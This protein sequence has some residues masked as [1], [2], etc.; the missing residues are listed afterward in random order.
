VRTI[1]R[2]V[3][4]LALISAAG[5]AAFAGA[6]PMPDVQHISVSINRPPEEVYD[7]ASDPRNLPRWAAGLARSDVK[8]DGDSWVADSPM[9]KIKIRFAERNAFGV[10]DHDV[11]TEAGVTIHNPMRVVPSGRGS[12]FSFT[13]IRQPGT[14][15]QQFAED[16]AAVEKDLKTLKVLLESSRESR[17]ARVE[18]GRAPVNTIQIYYEI[19]GPTEGT[20]LVLLHGGGSTIDVTFGRILPFLARHRRVIAVEEQGHGRT[21]DRDTPVRFET[22]ADDVAGLLKHLQIDKA[23]LFG[24]SNG[25]NVALQVAIRHPQRVRKLVFGSS[26]TTKA[27]ARPEFW[28]FLGKADFSNMPQPLK[29]AFL[30][31]NPDPEQ[32]RIMHDKDLERMRSFQDVPGADVRSIRAA[33]LVLIGDRDIVWPEHAVELVKTIPGARLMVLVGG[34]GDFMGEAVMTQRESRYPELTAGLIEEFLDAQE[35]PGRTLP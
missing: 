12:E 27:G 9:G 26:I 32:L 22:S 16:Q 28:E 21:S 23:D 3:P 8:K 34:H 13:L 33:T 4:P 20:P 31:V 11:T 30:R 35:P 24:F 25:A 2:L 19:H 10:L 18:S 29:D 7:F 1:M 15:D 6:Q 14:T 17:S 5:A